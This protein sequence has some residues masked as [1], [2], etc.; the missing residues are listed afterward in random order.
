MVLIGI[1]RFV[2]SFQSRMPRTLEHQTVDAVYVYLLG[3]SHS[4]RL[5]TDIADWA[6]DNLRARNHA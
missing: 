6:N 5:I 4:V 1:F 2:R 3:A